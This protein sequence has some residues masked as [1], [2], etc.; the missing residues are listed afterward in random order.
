MFI[1]H[2]QVAWFQLPMYAQYKLSVGLQAAVRTPHICE[3]WAQIANCDLSIHVKCDNMLSQHVAIK[4]LHIWSNERYESGEKCDCSRSISKMM[5]GEVEAQ[6][7]RESLLEY[8]PLW[9]HCHMLQHHRISKPQSN[10][11]VYQSSKQSQLLKSNKN[12]SSFNIHNVRL[13][14]W[15]AP[16]LGGG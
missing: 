11:C 2:S 15:G 1:R 5:E 14:W 12:I 4:T 13:C 9:F 7:T 16:Q 8:A 10:Y 6:V 3:R